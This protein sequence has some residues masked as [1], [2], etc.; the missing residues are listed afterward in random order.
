M[1][2]IKQ[3]FKYNKIKTISMKNIEV[4]A[5]LN[6]IADY[7]EFQNEPFKVRAYRKAALMINGLSEDI[8][9][10]WNNNKLKEL[11][12]IGEGIAKKIDDF[13][14]NGRSKHLDELKKKTP[15]DMEQLGAIEGIG[16]KTI[17]KLYSKLKIKNTKDLEKA[18]KE[19]SIQNIEGLG[20]T[21]EKNI[22]QSIAFAKNS[23]KR[24]PLG[25]ALSDAEEIIGMLKTLKEVKRVNIAGS[26]RRMKE[27]IGDIDILVTS[28]NPEKVI[29]FFT[30]M[31]NV[32]QVLAKGPTKSSIRIENIQ[33]DL[34]VLPD[35][36]Y[37]AA[38]L[39]FTG[40][41]QHNIELRK[42]AIQKRMKLSEYG[43][44]D[45]KTNKIIAGDT[46]CN[47]S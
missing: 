46:G 34:R 30:K 8:E 3:N 18:A 40:S 6:E 11:P 37:G 41:Q 22:L 25:F 36:I 10:V 24:V 15:V 9:Q 35:N 42:I 28:S 33:A 39:Y 2:F 32:Q 7:L 13:L 16:P 38:L 27:T 4:A 19:G 1:N 47:A 44:F 29:D 45:K 14:K 26:A 43:L 31:P 17:L 23:S 5:L 20:P 21:V 12:G